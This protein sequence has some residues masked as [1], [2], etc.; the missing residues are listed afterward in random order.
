MVTLHVLRRPAHN[1]MPP[2]RG[3]SS[4]LG[5][6]RGGHDRA[7]LAFKRAGVSGMRA[8]ALARRGKG[9]VLWMPRMA[10]AI[11][12]LA[13]PI[14]ALAQAPPPGSPIPRILPPSPP[15][16]GPAV[17]TPAL[18]APST[19]VPAKPVR[20][21]NVLIEG[22][23]AYPLAEIETL[24]Q[25]LVGPATSL[26]QIDAARLKILQLYR[27]DGYVLSAVSVNMD[28]ATGRLRFVVTEGRIA[29]VKLD[30][31]IGPAGTQV[32]RFLNR[33]TEKTPIDSATLERYLL[34]AQDVPGVTLHAVL[35]P[36]ADEPGAL[37]LI[38]QVSRQAVSGLVTMDNRAFVNT[39]PV[40]G[41]AVVDFNSFTEFGEKSEISLYH[42]FPNSETFGQA[43]SEFF[44]GASGL[45]F[46]FYAGAGQT[47]PTGPLN[48]EQYHGITTVWG[49]QFSYPVIRSR[50]QTLNLHLSYDGIQSTINLGAPAIRASYDSISAFRLSADYA[51]SDLLFGPDHSALNVISGRVSQGVPIL[52]ATGDNNPNAPRIGEQTTF[53]KFDFQASRTQTLF[54]PWRDATVALE[55]LVAGQVTGNVLPLTEEFYLGG[56]Q[57]TRGYYAGQVVG[58]KALAAT[59][60]LQ[61]NTVF[62]LSRFHLPS[63]V[64]TQ[65]YLFYDW[66]ET[67]NNQSTDPNVHLSS[68]GGGARIQL[69]PRVEVDFEGLARFNRYPNGSGPG[70]S[71]LYGGAFYW[72]VLARF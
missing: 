62:D 69:T 10:G 15:S 51:L 41:L 19:E 4:A 20:V 61:L 3:G 21:T 14:P 56:M 35:Q 36:S 16:V 50:Q 52:G 54:S 26:T 63:D 48:Q 45:K 7:E 55:G 30:G 28:V 8:P 49:G 23:T 31:D 59:A 43:S 1:M 40:E 71:P 53:T 39:G 68:A 64:S 70:I 6:Q 58:D 33:L 42:A 60:E 13:S 27:S 17:P 12:L 46:R 66:G 67:W 29:S 57:Y 47:W 11:A 9:R 5:A 37:N 22:V 25:G 2:A 24:T 72:R 65:F 32:L 44:I 18:P 34:L 38:A